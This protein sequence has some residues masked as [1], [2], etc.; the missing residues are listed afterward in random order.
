MSIHTVESEIPL[1]QM[2]YFVHALHGA[3]TG[4]DLFQ[5][6]KEIATKY[7]FKWFV[8]AERPSEHTTLKDCIFV[9][10]W[11]PELVE[12]LMH[13]EPLYT[14]DFARQLRT[15]TLPFIL[16]SPETEITPEN[17]VL[18]EC[19]REHGH[20][21]MF[22]LPMIGRAD[23]EFDGNLVFSGDREEPGLAETMQLTFIALHAHVALNRLSS[24]RIQ[25]K[26]DLSKRQIEILTLL[27]NGSSLKEIEK[28]MKLSQNTVG[29]HLRNASALLNARTRT[30]T[31]A[32][33]IRNQII[34]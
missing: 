30:E 7:N 25:P 23:D 5:C 8:A 14:H 4:Y 33:A 26:V 6:L 28:K 11:R 17:R 27:S 1:E 15:S 31:V 2:N 20:A 19:H 3:H 21:M 29:F 22:V 12:A 10:N 9:T 16:L 24:G 13:H 18:A 32:K 34:K